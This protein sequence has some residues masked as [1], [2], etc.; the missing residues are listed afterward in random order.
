MCINPGI[1]LQKNSQD[2]Q[3]RIATPLAAKAWG[4]NG[5]VIGRP[6]TQAADPVATYHQ[7]LQQWRQN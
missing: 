7:I 5:L 3:Q 6:I 4:S 2:D 1:R